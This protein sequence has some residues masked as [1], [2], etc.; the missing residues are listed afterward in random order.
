V[1]A[2][3]LV[4]RAL[5][6]SLSVT[7]FA[8]ALRTR[9]GDAAYLLRHRALL[10]RSLVALHVVLPAIA[11]V[12]V[13]V[14]PLHAAVRLALVT[15]MISPIPA[16]LPSK[17][18]RAGGDAPYAISL[19]AIASMLSV[20]VVPA[21]VAL[22]GAVAGTSMHVA[23]RAIARI[24]GGGILAP[25]ALGI[26]AAQAAPATAGRVAAPLARVAS[27][28]LLAAAIPLVVSQ[29]PAMRRLLGDGTLVV[30]VA[31]LVVAMGVGF[32]LG[33]PES[34]DRRVLA[35]SSACRHPGVAAAVAG[36]TFPDQPLAPAAVLLATLI[37][38]VA[39]LP[40]VR[41]SRPHASRAT[42]RRAT[43]SPPPRANV[44]PG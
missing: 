22:I 6:A 11:L 13:S 26:F 38:T 35:L 19:L 9:A 24:V 29:W 10:A 42:S 40:L 43:S 21:T 1:T 25:L 18:L 37:G 8:V 7:V 28:G 15:L 5:E 16:V 27:Y 4:I 44:R 12:V 20:V 14:V 17:A 31:L 30:I 2:A 39:T 3:T 41:H 23:P 32:A 34:S 33:G 36:A